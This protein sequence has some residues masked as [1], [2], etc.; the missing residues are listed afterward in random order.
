VWVSEDAGKTWSAIPGQLTGFIPH[1]GKLDLKAGLLYVSYTEGDGPNDGVSGYLYRLNI[2]SGEWTDVSPPLGT[3]GFGGL[4]VDAQ[5]SGTLMVAALNDW[6]PDTLIWRSTDFGA[7][8]SPIWDWGNYPTI[9]FYYGYD[10][11]SAP[12]VATGF[13]VNQFNKQVGWWVEALAIDPFNR[14][15]FLY[16]TGETVYG[17]KDLTNWDTKHNITLSSLGYGMEQTAVQKLISPSSGSHLLSGVGDVGGWLHTDINTPPKTSYINPMYATVV[18][19]DWA[20]NAP[21]VIVRVGNDGSGTVQQVA[22]SL[23]GGATWNPDTKVPI[24]ANSGNIALSA[25]GTTTLSMEGSGSAIVSIGNTS[26]VA[27]SGLP[28]G[29]LVASDKKNA[30]Y[31]YGASGSAVYV[32]STNGASF[33]QT[34]TVSGTINAISVNPSTAGNVLVATSAGLYQSADFG[35]TFKTV[36]SAVTNGYRVS[37]GAASAAGK[38]N[39]IFVGGIVGGK[40]GYFRTDDN[41]ASWVQVNNASYGFQTISSNPIVADSRVHGRLYVGTNGR[42]TFYGDIS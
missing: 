14:D 5:K 19:L 9:N 15:H 13:D 32:S 38:P 7:T 40:E 41:G 42:G 21:N 24:S 34:A 35:K 33:T 6:W 3:Y 16:G 31:F 27:V 30:A 20:G 1:K 39:S 37:V 26:Y 28:S 36:G 18:D 23:D 12:W 29:A 25:N 11:S 8:W 17:S 10:V 22:V 4:D 2:T